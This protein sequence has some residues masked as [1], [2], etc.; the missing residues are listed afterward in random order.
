MFHVKH[1]TQNM[2]INKYCFT[3]VWKIVLKQKYKISIETG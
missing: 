3:V 2:S 1:D